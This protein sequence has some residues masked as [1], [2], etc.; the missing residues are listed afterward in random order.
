[1]VVSV[2]D[3]GIKCS[4]HKYQQPCILELGFLVLYV[5]FPCN[6][7]MHVHCFGQ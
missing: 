6:D 4:S 1:M 7:V 5:C 3:H 2:L